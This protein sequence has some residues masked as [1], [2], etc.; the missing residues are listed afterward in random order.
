MTGATVLLAAIGHGLG[1]REKVVITESFGLKSQGSVSAIV[2][3]LTVYSLTIE[4]I[5]AAIFYIHW[6]LTGATQYSLF[7]AIFHAVSAFNNCGMDLFGNFNSL[8]TQQ[9]DVVILVITAI[10]IILGGLGYL[11]VDDIFHYKR[12]SKL[13]L[14]SK[15]VF[16]TT[17]GLL[18]SGTIYYF[19]AEFSSAGTLG[20]L[21]IP[22]KIIV[23]FFQ[24]VTARTAGFS[25]INIGNLKDISLFFTMLLMFIGGASGSA[26][27][28]VKVNTFGLLIIVAINSLRGKE[29]IEAFGKEIPINNIN[30]AIV[31]I[32][33]FI[34]SIFAI[35]LLLS[36]TETFSFNAI[37]F[38]IFSA[39][40]TV[41]LSTGITSG[42][43]GA[44]RIII[45]IAMFIGR[46]GPL[47]LLAIVTGQ[48][49][50]IDKS[51]PHE[52]IRIG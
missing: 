23:A 6:Q 9:K 12:F 44:G 24:S 38:E 28:G 1:L 33:F 8:V 30:R 46:L 25:A 48:Q 45:V 22:E 17:L 34:T 43:S 37:L 18:I 27:G 20:A 50:P 42:L 35:A 15:I 26:A 21:T 29:R 40:S 36:V 49:R 11:I 10:L 39:M 51:Y 14:E 31:L 32:L 16:L 2:K 19:I 7:T 3:K 5:G 52:T 4:C 13:S 47:T 41:G